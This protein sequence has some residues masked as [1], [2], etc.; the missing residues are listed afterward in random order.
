MDDALVQ[1]GQFLQTAGASLPI[2][3]VR[4]LVL[5]HLEK[6]VESTTKGSLLAPTGKAGTAARRLF[7]LHCRLQSISLRQLVL[8]VL[9]TVVSTEH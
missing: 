9:G 1:W 4:S 8:G 2:V 3:D 5:L 6:S 7:R